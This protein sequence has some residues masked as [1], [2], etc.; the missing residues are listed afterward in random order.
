MEKYRVR[1]Q[2]KKNIYIHN[3]LSNAAF[4][5]KKSVDSR[6]KEGNR[7]GIAFEVMACLSMLAFSFEARI[8]F[9]G[10]KL[11]QEKW[12][13]RQAFNNKVGQVINKVKLGLPEQ[14]RP[15][16]SI[17]KL[18]IFRDSIAHGKPCTIEVDEV[19]EVGYDDLD[20]VVDLSAGWEDFCSE[21]VMVEIYE[22]IEEIWQLLLSKSGLELFETITH[23]S[24]GITLIEKI[25][26]K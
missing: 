20:R 12:K 13:E 10:S 2:A 23:G 16:I 6:V 7:E 8:N 11:Y 22:D 26:D 24:G 15:F 9:L 3:D 18:K 17:E 1:R 25:T 21:S 5:F 4:H 14:E 19:V